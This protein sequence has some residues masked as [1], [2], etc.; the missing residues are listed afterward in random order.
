MKDNGYWLGRLETVRMFNRDPHEIL[1]RDD[2]IN[3]ITPQVLQEIFKKYFVVDRSTVLTLLPAKA[4][5]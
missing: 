2:R 4:T 3:A 1:T 5:P